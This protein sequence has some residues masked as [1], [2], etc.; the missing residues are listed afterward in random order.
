M[1]NLVSANTNAAAMMI[2]ERAADF[3][4]EDRRGLA[5]RRG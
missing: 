3:I 2:G 4:L 5:G 1:P